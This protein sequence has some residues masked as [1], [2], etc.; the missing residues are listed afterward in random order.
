MD[1]KED[2]IARLN[3]ETKEDVRDTNNQ[4]FFIW[5]LRRRCAGR[6]VDRR[7]RA[8]KMKRVRSQHSNFFS[9][10]SFR[11]FALPGSIL[12]ILPSFIAS[13]TVYSS[14]SSFLFIYATL[15]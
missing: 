11:F 8:E 10:L 14:F 3:M 15:A 9:F 4:F 7:S 1:K 12:C 5:Q 13:E 6:G 2:S